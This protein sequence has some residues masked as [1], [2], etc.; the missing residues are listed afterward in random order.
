MGAVQSHPRTAWKPDSTGVI[1]TSDDP[2]PNTDS[3][4]WLRVCAGGFGQSLLS[5]VRVFRRLARASA[6]MTC[7]LLTA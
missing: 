7:H 6:A 4:A 1:A 2:G 5:E 3:N